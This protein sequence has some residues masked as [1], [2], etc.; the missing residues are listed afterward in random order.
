MIRVTQAVT[1]KCA[2]FC[3]AEEFQRTKHDFGTCSLD[4]DD[5]A[6]AQVGGA[7]ETLPPHGTLK[8][9]SERCPLVGGEAPAHEARDLQCAPLL[10]D[11]CTRTSFQ[12]LPASL[13]PDVQWF[14]GRVQW[15]QLS[16]GE[17]DRLGYERALRA[18]L[19]DMMDDLNRKIQRN[20]SR[21]KQQTV[22][23]L[24][25][26]DQVPGMHCPGALTTKSHPCER[27]LCLALVGIR[28]QFSHAGKLIRMFFTAS[29]LVCSARI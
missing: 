28:Q 19:E 29:R 1:G 16:D 11:L 20:E 9:A 10:A 12:R 25:S 22:P 17:K 18:V 14:G 5:A 4:H 27:E 15:E 24:P 3:P 21:L 26:S 7:W 6:K 13:R 23:A 2:G 8:A